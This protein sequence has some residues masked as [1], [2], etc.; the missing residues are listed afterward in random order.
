MNLNSPAYIGS[1]GWQS[2]THPEGKRYYACGV[3]P[4]IITEVDLL[5]DIISAAV[6]AWAALI[7]EWAV[8]LDLELGPSVEL[9]VEPEVD[10]GLCDYYIIDH[11]NRAVFWLEDSST[12]EL[13]LPPAC[14]HQ[15]L[16]LA[17][18]ENYWKHVEMFSMHIEDLPGALEE[19]IAIYLHG[20]ADL[21]TSASST[22]YFTPE[23]TDVHLDI[24]MKCRSTPKNSI[25]FSLIGRLWG[26][27]ANAKFQN[28][29]GEDHCRLDHTTRV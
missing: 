1:R 5:D 7:L 3:S 18:E 28:F 19:L 21:A 14:S 29:Y 24:L 6:D 12:S 16:K 9:F 4:R 11:S 13:G 15:H 22:F 26:Y 23:V 2:Y 25:M 20:R 10:T 8:E 27:M 17:L